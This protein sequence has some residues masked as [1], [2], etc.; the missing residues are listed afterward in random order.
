MP[1]VSQNF[2][3][4]ANASDVV[5][6]PD[7]TKLYVAERDGSLK[8]FELATQRRDERRTRRGAAN[9][10]FTN[11]RGNANDFVCTGSQVQSSDI[12]FV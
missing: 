3:L 4:S 8:F 7:Q 6:W 10:G 9:G 12:L 11:D 1:G 2:T 5:F